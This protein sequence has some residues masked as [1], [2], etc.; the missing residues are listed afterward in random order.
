M[1]GGGI[2]T[3]RGYP[4]RWVCGYIIRGWETPHPV[5]QLASPAPA[6]DAQGPFCELASP[7]PLGAA[8]HTFTLPDR[9]PKS[10]PAANWPPP[11][12]PSQARRRPRP[13]ASRRAPATP[14]G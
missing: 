5:H 6:P 14:H 10:A 12:P 13:R 8:V 2:Y 9:P 1:E 11:A 4:W 7:A 3:W